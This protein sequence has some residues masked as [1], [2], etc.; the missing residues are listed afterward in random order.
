MHFELSISCSVS[1]N[2]A[3]HFAV[4]AASVMANNPDAHVRFHMLHR[5]VSDEHLGKIKEMETLY[6]GRCQMVFHRVADG[7]FDEA[8][9]S[10]VHITHECYFRLLLPELILDESRTLYLDI[11]IL[12]KGNLRPLFEMDIDG[13]AC[14]AVN[15]HV[16]PK[17]SLMQTISGE[18]GTGDDYFNSGVLLL[19]LDYIREKHLDVACKK[20]IAEY[21]RE[22]GYADQ[23]VLNYAFRNQVKWISPRWNFLGKWPKGWKGPRERPVI[24]HYT[25]FSQKPWNCKAVR[26]T[27][28]PYLYYMLKSPFRM[29]APSFL[30]LH[31]RAFLWWRYHKNCECCLDI[32]GVR[33][34]RSRRG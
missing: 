6:P 8:P 30:L 3:Q 15:E 4:L 26:F 2:F 11:D 16:C 10:S 7:L 13:Y 32:L 23:D 14:A 29:K 20:V 22:I 33:V 18:A 34:W 19:N 17:G 27:W 28:I 1:D 24:R 9:R 5:N 21:C 31:L 12:V 25:S